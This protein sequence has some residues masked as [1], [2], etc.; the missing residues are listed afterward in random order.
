VTDPAFLTILIADDEEGIRSLLTHWLA[1]AGHRVIVAANGREASRLVRSQRI[2]LVITDVVMPD[3]DGYELIA[4][5]RKT[6]PGARI[7]AISGGGNY[8]HGPECLKMAK[9]LGAHAVVL[10][11]F[12]WEQIRA[13]LASLMPKSFPANEKAASASA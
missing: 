10:K 2:D 11:P 8:L 4:E 3:G 13:G 6:Q 9:G 1:G 5:L 7:L 12:N